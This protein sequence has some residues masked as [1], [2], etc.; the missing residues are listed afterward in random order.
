MD[1]RYTALRFV[2]V[3]ARF[4]PMR[5]GYF[6]AECAGNLLF[7]LSARY[8]NI[9]G[10]NLQRVT[11]PEQDERTLRQK[12]RGVFKNVTKNY[13]DLIKLSQLRLE[14]L[15][16]N[17]TIEGWHHLADAVNNSRGV[18][19][20]TAHLGSFEHAARV[21]A[22]RG[23]KM[24]I[25]VEAFDS[26][27]FLRNIH[28]LRQGNG[29]R[30]LPVSVSAMKESMRILRHGGT[31]IIVCDRDIQGN[32]VKVNFCGEETSLPLGAVSLALR[33]GAAIIPVFS[34]RKSSDRF[35]IYIEPPLELVDTENRNHSVRVNVEKLAAIMER[36]I[37]QYP[38]QWVALEPIW[39]N[40]AAEINSTQHRR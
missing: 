36:Y 33:T 27:P 29:S 16:E 2:F 37:R 40:E 11:G 5:P 38:E 13:F 35:A 1:I 28:K 26:A 7:L 17:V 19:I 31:M 9:I 6:L 32:G 10:N 18:I 14:N 8:R 20:A 23:I 22:L 3:M 15:E 25:F 12:V 4:V 30:I 21:L 24:T 34:V 39:R